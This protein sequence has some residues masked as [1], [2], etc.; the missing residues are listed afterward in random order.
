MPMSQITDKLFGNDV[1]DQIKGLSEGRKM[2]A[3][4]TVDVS[5]AVESNSSC[6]RTPLS[7]SRSLF[8]SSR[9]TKFTTGV[10]PFKV[11]QKHGR[12]LIRPILHARDS[13]PKLNTKMSLLYQN[14]IPQIKSI[15]KRIS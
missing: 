14:E 10:R 3:L 1:V 9:F 4:V 12:I 13:K 7:T 15:N 11:P 6:V 8:S 2:A 5:S